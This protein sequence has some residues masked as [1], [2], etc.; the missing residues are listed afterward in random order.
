[1]IG[2]IQVIPQQMTPVGSHLRLSTILVHQVGVFPMAEVMV[3]GRKH[4]VHLQLIP[5]HTTAP[6]KVFLSAS[7]VLQPLGILLRVLATAALGRW[8]VSAAVATIGQLLLSIASL[9]ACT[10]TA[11]A[12]SV[13]PATAIE[14]TG[15][16]SVASKSDSDSGS[17]EPCSRAHMNMRFDEFFLAPGAR[18]QA[19][20]ASNFKYS[21]CYDL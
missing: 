15:L 17:Y 8:V 6:I 4:L 10:S 2:I 12:T 21:Y 20:S 13:H 16:A 5:G 11:M 3:F 7:A 1:M 18:R 9:T 14:R 19:R